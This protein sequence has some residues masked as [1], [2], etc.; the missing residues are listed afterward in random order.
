MR[1]CSMQLSSVTQSPTKLY[2]VEPHSCTDFPGSEVH[3]LLK[4]NTMQ[5]SQMATTNNDNGSIDDDPNNETE[6]V[7]CDEA[8]GNN[9][10]SNQVII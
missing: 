8:A 6:D 2:R 1:L 7:N 9:S 3:A 5:Y 10:V 4:F